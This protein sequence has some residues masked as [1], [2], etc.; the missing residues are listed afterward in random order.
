M[1]HRLHVGNLSATT[2]SAAL[3]EAFAS[4]GH[5]VAKVSLVMSRD[6]GISRGFAFLDLDSD[7]AAAAAMTKLQGAEL[8][9]KAMRISIANPPKSRFG[10]PLVRPAGT[11]A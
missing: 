8:D 7:E 1:N 3:G 6:A 5:P 2:T 4:A 10:G 9:G 11:S